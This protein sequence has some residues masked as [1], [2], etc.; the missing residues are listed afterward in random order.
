M[1]E[2]MLQ[3]HVR[4]TN[5]EAA[6]PAALACLRPALLDAEAAGHVTSLHFIRKGDRWRVRYQVAD[7]TD[8]A[9]VTA[10][11]TGSL[12]DSRVTGWTPVIYE[13]EVHA[14]G[15]EFGMDAA[16]T[17]FH[18]DSRQVLD[19]L[20]APGER[21]RR[22]ELAILL[23]TAL[24]R[25]ADQ[26]WYEQGDVWAKVAAHRPAGDAPEQVARLGPALQRLVSVDTGP[27][28]VLAHGALAFASPWL[29]VHAR[30]GRRLVHLAHDGQLTRGLRSTLAH[31][32]LFHFNR[33]GL[34]PAVQ[35]AIAATASSLVFGKE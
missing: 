22:C 19:Y 2:G 20:A 7:R 13:P 21:D 30:A 25:G 1:T 28:S 4:F 5:Q 14:F 16:H 29:D 8:P 27:R 34:P 15:G 32:V 3:L 12:A 26:E 18:E 35:G 6:E 9:K 23:V 24:L 33:M 31:H 11:I 10:A 17:F